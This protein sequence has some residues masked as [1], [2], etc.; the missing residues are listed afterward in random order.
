VL[1]R[2]VAGSKIRGEKLRRMWSHGL[3]RRVGHA[4]GRV[5]APGGQKSFKFEEAVAELKIIGVLRDGAENASFQ[6]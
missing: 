6:S 5:T 4:V 2:Q 3:Q 1:E